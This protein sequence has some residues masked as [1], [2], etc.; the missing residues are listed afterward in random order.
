MNYVLYRNIGVINKL[1]PSDVLFILPRTLIRIEYLNVY[2]DRLSQVAVKETKWIYLRTHPILYYNFNF[3]GNLAPNQELDFVS[4]LEICWA[5]KPT[6]FP[7]QP[8]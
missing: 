6:P 7:Q 8:V 5:L 1:F 3:L 4:F 2:V